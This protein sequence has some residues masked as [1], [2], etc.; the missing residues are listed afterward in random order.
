MKT[1]NKLLERN[2]KWAEEIDLDD[3]Q[4]FHVQSKGQSPEYLW[5]GCSDSRVPPSEITATPPG[6]IFVQR[7]IANMVVHTDFN[8]L[9]VVYYAVIVLKVKHIIVFG[10]N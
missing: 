9:N 1:I 8:L 5:I 2:A 6:S 7:N 10:D 3:Y 4:F